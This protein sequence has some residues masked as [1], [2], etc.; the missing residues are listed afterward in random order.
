M[1]ENFIEGFDDGLAL[2]RWNFSG[3]VAADI[4]ADYGRNGKG[5][6]VGDTPANFLEYV[7]A[8]A[9]ST[10][11]M[12]GFAVYVVDYGGDNQPLLTL[13][14]SRYNVMIGASGQRIGYQNDAISTVT[15]QW[16][17]NNSL[18]PNAWHYVEVYHY[19][20]DT[21]G[22]YTIKVDGTTVVSDTGIDTMYSGQANL[23]CVFGSNVD[24]VYLD[25]IWIQGD[26]SPLT[27]KGDIEVVTLLPNANGNSSDLLGSDSNKTDNYL[28]VDNNAAIPPATTEYVG[29]AVQGEKDTYNMED[30]TGTPTVL[31]VQGTL[32]AANSDTGAKQIRPVVR[33]GST[34]YTGDTFPLQN[35]VYVPYDYMWETDPDTA[36]AW[37]YG[38][39]NSMEFGQEV[40]D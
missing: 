31:A 3:G 29:S 34:D 6:R 36:S 25:D 39:V 13:Y 38:G 15:T 40:R 32:F 2:G 11:F 28:L 30:L 5:V 17:A 37:L 33:S 7:L 20:H 16:A 14:T 4:H 24:D 1:A 9:S 35:S 12:V 10:Y 26:T 27:F 18:T 23:D 8:D 22:F 21:A 19:L